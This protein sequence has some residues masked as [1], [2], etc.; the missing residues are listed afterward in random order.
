MSENPAVS[1]AQ[2]VYWRQMPGRAGLCRRRAPDSALRAEEV[3]HWPQTQ[4]EQ[5]CGVGVAGASNRADSCFQTGP[6]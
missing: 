3:A 4:P 6:S 2:C 1:C 5:G